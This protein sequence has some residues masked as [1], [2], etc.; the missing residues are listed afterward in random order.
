MHYLI[1][2]VVACGFLLRGTDDWGWGDGYM[3]T[4]LRCI[5]TIKFLEI[6]IP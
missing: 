5:T 6:V 1:I 2:I 4:Q 3:V